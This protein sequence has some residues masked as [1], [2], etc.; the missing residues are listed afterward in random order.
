MLSEWDQSDNAPNLAGC[1]PDSGVRRFTAKLLAHGGLA[2]WKATLR[3]PA[4]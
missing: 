2:S 3:V 1:P 4:D